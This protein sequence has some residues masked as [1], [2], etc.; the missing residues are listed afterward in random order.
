MLYID[1]LQCSNFNRDVFLNL[2]RGGL[3]A[4]TCTV[5]FWEDATETMDELGRWSDLERENSDLILIA[6]SAADI[7]LAAES[8]RTAILL[9]SQNASPVEDRIRYV[10]L[11]AHMGLRVMQL[12]YN[13]Q[14][15]VGGSCYE[16]VDSG[17]TRFGKELVREMNS[18]GMLIDLSHVGEKTSFEAVDASEVP[19]AVT[20]ANPSE[21]YEH[22]R[23]KSTAFLKYLSQS[24]GVLGLATY[25]NIAGPWAE[26]SDKWAEMVERTVDIVGIDHVAVG[27]DLAENSSMSDLDW[28]RK[29]RWTRTT[30]YGAGGKQRPG[31]VS[32]PTW[33]RNAGDFQELE[34]AL[35][36]R[37]FRE[38]HIEA[39]MG[40]NWRRLYGAV[41][42]VNSETGNSSIESNIE[43][44]SSPLPRENT[45]V[46]IK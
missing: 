45:Y 26:T 43:L 27:T 16:P 24:G 7:D 25:P 19:V 44:D 39:V 11:F 15:A 12:T 10:E 38:R 1:G 2:R 5:A 36:R 20:H 34:N 46:T 23:N 6:R 13:N 29:G 14:N 17:L 4:I 31:V 40:L 3:S 42:D 8:G 28:M 18:V 30:Q 37:G 22:P 41:M 32:D 9:G 21:L 35:Q 33:F